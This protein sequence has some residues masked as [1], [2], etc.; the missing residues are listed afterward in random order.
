MLKVPI[1]KLIVHVG[2]KMEERQERT[3]HDEENCYYSNDDFDEIFE[4]LEENE[5]QKEEIESIAANVAKFFL[6]IF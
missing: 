3:L 1:F 6:L 2:S 4:F 5:I